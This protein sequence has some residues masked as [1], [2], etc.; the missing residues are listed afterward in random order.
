MERFIVLQKIK[1]MNQSMWYHIT[2]AL[3]KQQFDIIY[4]SIGC[5]MGHYYYEDEINNNEEKKSNDNIMLITEKNNQQY[6]E[7]L[8]NYTNKLIVLVDPALEKD[9]QII[10]YY[11][12]IYKYLDRV[13]DENSKIIVYNNNEDVVIAAHELYMFQEYKKNL[14]EIIAH[15]ISSKTKLI[16]QDFTGNDL[17]QEYEKL[18]TIFNKNDIFKHISF[19]VTYNDGGCYVELPNVLLV[20]DN[21][22]FIQPKYMLLQNIQNKPLREL[23]KIKRLD[24]INYPLAWTYLKSMETNK[25]ND[26]DVEHIFRAYELYF[27][28]YGIKVDNSKIYDYSY[29]SIHIVLLI[30]YVMDDAI[31]TNEL[32][33]PTADI[34]NCLIKDRD[35]KK[36][37]EYITLLKK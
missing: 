36:F 1:K 10:K 13:S 3:N 4:F 17:T 5:S 18:F 33:I 8:N 2:N 29:A 32:D 15:C 12:R 14:Y 34:I 20:D 35:I 6:P 24:K 11:N 30:T 7:F 27:M 31:K 25:F 26:S 19:D 23:H 37:R 22:D 28:I 21:N 16:V 9:L